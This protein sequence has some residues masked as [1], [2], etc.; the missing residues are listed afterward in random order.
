MPRTV[1]KGQGK[2]PWKIV[3]RNTEEPSTDELRALQRGRAARE[4]QASRRAPTEHGIAQHERRA[5]KS[6]YL[7]RMLAE[8]E[9][10]ERAASGE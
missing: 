8:R 4:R 6:E 9:R 3:D 10:S 1:R 5:A 7:E 2:K